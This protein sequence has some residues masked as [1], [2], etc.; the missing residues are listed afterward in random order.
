M[1]VDTTKILEKNFSRGKLRDGV[2]FLPLSMFIVSIE[3]FGNRS[4]LLL[5]FPT[6]IFL[7]GYN[8]R[9]SVARYAESQGY[10]GNYDMIWLEAGLPGS[11]IDAV[12]RSGTGT[13]YAIPSGTW[14]D[15]DRLLRIAVAER[16]TFDRN[17][18][19][20]SDRFSTSSIYIYIFIGLCV[21]LEKIL[22]KND[23]KFI[24]STI[25]IQRVQ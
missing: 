13:Q 14:Y 16:N 8:K 19:R 10:R 1:E 24:Q 6:V 20:F 23:N 25:R 12:R 2:S 7:K 9:Y 5:D 17:E 11:R 18:E 3:E 15:L 21:T 22:Q 4:S